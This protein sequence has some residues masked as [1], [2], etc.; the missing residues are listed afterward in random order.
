M[1]NDFIAWCNDAAMLHSLF[2]LLSL[3]ASYPLEKDFIAWWLER[4]VGKHLPVA[5]T[6]MRLTVALHLP[7]RGLLLRENSQCN[8]GIGSAFFGHG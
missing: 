7:K 4:D 5:W 2:A 6:S 1:V 8:F 3:G